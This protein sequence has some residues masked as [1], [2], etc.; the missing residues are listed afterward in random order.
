MKRIVALLKTKFAQNTSW[1]LAGRIYQIIVNLAVSI[2][3]VRY[4]GPSNYGLINYAASYAALLTAFCTLGT[5]DILVNELISDRNHEGIILGSTIVGRL[6]S[7]LLSVITITL[8]VFI[9]NPNEPLTVW[10]AFI[11]S[12]SLIFQSFEAIKYW[13]QSNLLSK[14]P[15]K[16]TMLARTI[17]AIYKI[18]LLLCSGSVVLFAAANAIDFTVEAILLIVAYKRNC[19]NGQNL[20]F[21]LAFGKNIF[22]KSHHFII[23]GFM[24]ALYGQMD[25][26][27]IKHMMNGTQ[28]GYYSAAI[29]ICSLWP[30]VLAAIIDSARPIIIERYQVDYIDY[31]KKLTQ[32]YSAILYIAFGVAFGISIFAKIII[33]I[34]YGSAYF[35]ATT[36][37]RI[38][39]W[40]TAFSYIGVARSI[41]SVP[42]NYQKYEKYI[43]LTGAIS[44]GIL[45][46]LLIP[47]LGIDG[48]AIATLSTQII[49]NLLFGF[50][51][52]ELRENN[53][54]ILKS[55]NLPGVFLK[56]G[57]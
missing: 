51:I 8:L 32:L 52:K 56:N 3:S 57:S 50:F 37:L 35:E 36:S 30:F 48:A 12:T 9:G 45:N 44:N 33:Y 25:K 23:S 41:W 46:A 38:A 22:S 1:I 26:I 20:K 49:T 7:S 43:A 29:Q 17:V 4:L 5:N 10:V 31:K 53:Y 13:Y 2:V 42:H 6:F 40:A 15:S 39:S 11:Y 16:I 19:S 21:S 18:V 54:L 14:I 27:M 47:R 24:V 28:V 34:L 55:L